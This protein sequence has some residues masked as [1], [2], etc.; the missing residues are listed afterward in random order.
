MIKI[1]TIN[2]NIFFDKFL[3]INFI[4]LE[5]VDYQDWIIKL[6]NKKSLI[7]KNTFFS[8]FLKDLEYLK[9]KIFHLMKIKFIANLSNWDKTTYIEKIIK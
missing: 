7:V 4:I 2:N 9:L 8:K 6:N 1:K 3:G 5:D